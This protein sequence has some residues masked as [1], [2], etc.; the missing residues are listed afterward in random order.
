[1]KHVIV[2]A[3][4]ALLVASCSA[5]D[6]SGLGGSDEP[7]ASESEAILNN[8]T[9]WVSEE[10]T[11][12]YGTCG[13]DAAGATRAGCSGSYCDNMR[14][15]CGPL[16]QGFTRIPGNFWW[17][18]NWISEEAPNNSVGCPVG[19]VMDGLMASGSYSDNVRIRCSPTTFP[20]QG[21]NCKWMPYFSEENGGTQY[22]D[23]DVQSLAVGVAVAVQCGGSYCDNMSYYICEP[24]CT[25]DADCL[26]SCNVTTGRCVIG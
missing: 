10:P 6:E 20:P 7:I 18:P 25:R 5:A 11:L 16:P 2:L 9:Q 19:Y 17:S 21:V 26:S 15:W 22:F 14:L 3:V 4:G 13:T 24:R 8:W 12:Y 1:M 23:Y